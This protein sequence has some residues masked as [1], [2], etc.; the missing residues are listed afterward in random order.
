MDRA[1]TRKFVIAAPKNTFWNKQAKASST[2]PTGRAL[3]TISS[4]WA[5]KTES[6][7]RRALGWHHSASSVMPPASKTAAVNEPHSGRENF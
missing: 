2:R 1:H 3:S 7:E 5:R 6:T 4:G